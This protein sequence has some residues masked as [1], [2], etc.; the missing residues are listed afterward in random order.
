M[1]DSRDRTSTV[2]TRFSDASRV[3]TLVIETAS[4]AC[5]VA[6]IDDGTV[7]DWCHEIVCRGHAERLLP[8][9]AG[10]RDGGRA[11]RVIVDIGPGSFTGVRV[12]V[13]A[14][15]A[16]GFAWGIPVT[17]YC[18]LALL[19]AI[20]GHSGEML[21]AINGGHGELF[22]GRYYGQPLDE[23]E[24]ARSLALSDAMRLTAPHITGN[25]AHLITKAGSGEDIVADARATT[26]LPQALTQLAPA[27]FYGRPADAKPMRQ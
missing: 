25:A 16:L 24:P 19:A 27:P 10:L 12:G 8:M 21:V 18:S 17:G 14:A 6:L 23:I 2:S 4:A 13:A 15:R 11:D 1:G 22:V 26:R 3:R 5:S 7:V 9:V 20:A